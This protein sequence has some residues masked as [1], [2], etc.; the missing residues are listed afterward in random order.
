MN[1]G[2]E[3]ETLELETK[4]RILEK[5][6]YTKRNAKLSIKR[7]ANILRIFTRIHQNS[8]ETEQ[9]VIREERQTKR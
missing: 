1:L 6:K 5:N 4:K 7:E 2:N 8:D 3:R 9:T